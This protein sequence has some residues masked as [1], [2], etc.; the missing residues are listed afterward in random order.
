VQVAGEFESGRA[1]Q[2]QVDDGQLGRRRARRLH[3]LLVARG[4]ANAKTS[5]AQSLRQAL[6]EDIVIVHEE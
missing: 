1:D 6:A 4:G 2:S 5:L 3:G